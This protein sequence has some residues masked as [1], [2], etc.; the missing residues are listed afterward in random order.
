MELMPKLTIVAGPNGSGKT[1]VTTKI[2]KHEWIEGCVYINPDNIAKDT[3]GDW[4]VAENVLKAAI[5]AVLLLFSCNS[6]D[7]KTD[8]DNAI[9]DKDSVAVIDSDAQDADIPI[10]DP[11]MI[12]ADVEKSDTDTTECLINL[13]LK[14][15]I[16]FLCISV[17]CIYPDGQTMAQWVLSSHGI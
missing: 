16:W 14:W 4:N 2:L 8:T 6:N 12:D 3:F 13:F 5:L 15:K 1:S 7:S 17:T 11:D 10:S 9:P